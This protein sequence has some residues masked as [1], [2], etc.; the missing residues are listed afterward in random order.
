MPSRLWSVA[1]AIAIIADTWCGPVLAAT[2]PYAPAAG[3]SV[4]AYPGRVCPDGSTPLGEATYQ[5]A[6]QYSGAVYCTFPAAEI[7]F[8][9]KCPEGFVQ[10]GTVPDSRAPFYRCALQGSAAA[11]AAGH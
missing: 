7:T 8:A 5:K 9:A 6:A 11:Q 10:T 1:V 3:A 4:F 2:P